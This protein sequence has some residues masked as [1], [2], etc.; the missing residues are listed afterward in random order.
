M[1][2]QPFVTRALRFGPL[3]DAEGRDSPMRRLFRLGAAALSDVELLDVLLDGRGRLTEA[4]EIL[5]A[6]GTL[7]ALC[8]E[9]PAVLSAKSGI[10]RH[11]T[12]ALLASVELGRRVRE[13]PEKRPT[14]STSESVFRFLAPR[15][16][17]LRREEFHVLY[18]T[19]RNALVRAAKV[20]EGSDSSCPVDPREVFSIALSTHAAAL[21]FA[22]NHPSGDPE[23]SSEDLSLTA[24]LVE[25]A[26]LLGISVLDHVIFGA[27]GYV[28]F[29]ERGLLPRRLSRS[30]AGIGGGARP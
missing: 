15:L 19:P 13:D 8:T 10:G 4:E 11:R 25:A 21:I 20:A 23:P 17:G 26:G 29:L 22:H 2:P 3:R 7:R 9:E 6:A 30:S 28:S 16:Q 1:K 24:Q 5:A 27:P 14:L 18:L 12:A